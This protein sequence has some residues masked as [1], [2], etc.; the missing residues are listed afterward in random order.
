MK[1][2]EGVV[3]AISAKDLPEEDQWGNTHRISLK[4]GEDW[5][6]LGSAKKPNVSIK[7]GQG[8]YEVKKG[9]QVA[10]VAQE[11]GNFL[12]AKRGDVKLVKKGGGSGAASSQ[13][14]KTVT[15]SASSKTSESRAGVGVDWAAKDAG[16]AASASIDKALRYIA[17]RNGDVKNDYA[18]ILS[19]ARDFQSMV[20]TLAAE[21]QGKPA[22]EPEKEDA[23]AK[24]TNGL[25]KKPSKPKP[26]EPE[27]EF[28]DDTDLF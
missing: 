1:L 21:I 19:I 27:E 23:P 5:V 14:T 7:E 8:W 3:E 12:N 16:A 26:V 2:I 4:I 17:L 15:S 18:S 20:K 13:T 24:L 11:N 9:D 25:V 10:V 6:G 28:E 22:A